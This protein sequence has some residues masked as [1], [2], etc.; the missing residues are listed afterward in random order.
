MQM[1]MGAYEGKPIDELPTTYLAWVVSQD[2]I[3][4]SRWALIE[5]IVRVLSARFS[6]PEKLLEELR[7]TEAPP[8][9]TESPERKAERQA[10][11]AEKLRQLEARRLEERLARREAWRVAKDQADM[12][13]ASE[14]LR[15]RLARNRQQATD[16]TEQAAGAQVIDFSDLV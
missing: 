14:K 10:E 7:V 5:E 4:F 9:R 16:T 11:R 3:R 1:P 2:A 15:A 6:E 8:A 12:K 13:R